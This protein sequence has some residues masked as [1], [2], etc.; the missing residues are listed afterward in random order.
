MERIAKRCGVDRPVRAL[1]HGVWLLILLAVAIP[2]QAQVVT[3]TV[4]GHI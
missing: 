3:V 4:N 1:S 2:L